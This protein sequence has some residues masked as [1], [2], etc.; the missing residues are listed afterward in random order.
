MAT[1]AVGIALGSDLLQVQVA[2]GFRQCALA[3]Q[4]FPATV[5]TIVSPDVKM[6]LANLRSAPCYEPNAFAKL[7]KAD[8][9]VR[10]RGMSASHAATRIKF[11]A[12]A[13][14]RCIDRVF[15]SPM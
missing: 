11:I 7:A 4:A 3:H 1:V 14:R 15:A 5:R 13:R 10:E 9:R 12:P 6:L 2:D 8:S